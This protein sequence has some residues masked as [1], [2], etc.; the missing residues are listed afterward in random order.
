[1]QG[2]LVGLR[3]DGN[4]LDAHF[5]GRFDDPAGDFAAVGNQNA[6]EHAALRVTPF[7]RPGDGCG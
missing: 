6:L 1:M 4:R 2:I 5:A 3:I 7:A